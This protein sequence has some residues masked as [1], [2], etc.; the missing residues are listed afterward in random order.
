MRVP[1]FASHALSAAGVLFVYTHD[2][3]GVGEDGP[4][5]EP[6]EQL[7]GASRDAEPARRSSE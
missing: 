5:H 7:D 1:R 2:S 4:T 3:V 6:V